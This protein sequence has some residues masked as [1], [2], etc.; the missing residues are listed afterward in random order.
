MKNKKRLGQILKYVVL[1]LILMFLLLPVFWVLLTSFKTNMESYQYP[2][3]F[4]PKK[5]TLQAYSDL[6]TKHNDFFV[7]YKNNFIVSGVT[8]VVTTFLAIFTGYALSRFKFKWN[9]LVMIALLSSQMFPI[10]S[11]MISLYGLMGKVHLLDTTIGLIFALIAAML[12]FSS[13]LMASFFDSIPKAIEESAYID[14]AGRMGILFKVVM[15]LVTPGMVAVGIY[16]F[17]MTWDDY[18]HAATLIQTDSLRT[19]SAGVSMRYL[20]ELSYDWSLI[21]TISIVG[22]LP[23]IILFFSF[24]KYMVKGLVAGAVKG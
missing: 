6:I 19:L 1:I 16:S 12:P 7:Y 8:A 21:N 10:V 11:R 13:I 18:L 22:M 14:G 3:T 24:Q 2:P 9:R 4:I 20:G 5:P 15:P 23:M 17:L